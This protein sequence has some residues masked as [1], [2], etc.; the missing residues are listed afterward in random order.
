[1][2]LSYNQFAGDS[3]S[4][5]GVGWGFTLPTM[6]VNDDMGTAIPGTKPGGDFFS[7]LSYQGTRLV[8]TG[9][10]GGVWHYKPEFSEQYV[11]IVYHP[12]AFEVATLGRTGVLQKE[13]IASGFEVINPDGSRLIFSGDPAIAEG[14]FDVAAPY[15][16]KWPLILQLN[17]DRD[18]VRFQH[19]KFGGR[20]YLTKVSFAGGR[21]VYEFELIDT[22]PSLVSHVTGTGQ[23]N[24][25]LYGRMTAKFDST[26]YAQWC[27]GYVGRAMD[28]STKFEVRAHPSCQAMAQQDLQSKID[29]KLRQ[30][31]GPTACNLSVRRYG[32]RRFDGRHREVPQHH[33]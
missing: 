11:V 16:T 7:R 4:G 6:V 31:A 12:E 24:A 15:V 27:L 32:R 2:M 8:F 18:A 23:R 9:A 1:M 29:Q 25:K 28:A 3:G 10:E 5:V 13:T 14:N 30:R 22:R 33:V 17:A 21:S 20:S 26:V 19:Q